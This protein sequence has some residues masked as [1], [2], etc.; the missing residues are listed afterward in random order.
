MQKQSIYIFLKKCV[1][2]V[3]FLLNILFLFT[4][5]IFAKYDFKLS[6][7]NFEFFDFENRILDQYIY[8]FF[9]FFFTNIDKYDNIF[10]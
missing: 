10:L 7:I 1:T 8:I 6:W 5:F 4:K 9:F 2:Q 3:F